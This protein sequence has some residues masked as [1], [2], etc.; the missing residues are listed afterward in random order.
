MGKV[1]SLKK[2]RQRDDREWR[3]FVRSVRHQLQRLNADQ[4]AAIRKLVKKHQ[5]KKA[6]KGVVV[7]FKKRAG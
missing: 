4:V 3:K 5:R 2:K 6:K 7:Q 1:A